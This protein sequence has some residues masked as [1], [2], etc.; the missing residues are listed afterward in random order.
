MGKLY[1]YLT[2]QQRTYS[3]GL[4]AD[5]TSTTARSIET[6]TLWR[7]TNTFIRG[8]QQLLLLLL[9]YNAICVL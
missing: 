5:G 6:T 4:R 7:Y 9:L 1:V 3:V 8:L 2:L